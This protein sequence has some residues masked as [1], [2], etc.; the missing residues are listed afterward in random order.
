M[1][2]LESLPFAR[3]ISGSTRLLAV[4]GDPVAHSLS[5]LMHNL[6]LAH[7]GF[8]YR[9]M[10]FHI[11]P[12]QLSEAVRGFAAM[13][14]RGFNAT[15]PHKEALATLMDELSDEARHLKAVNT[16]AI[17]DDGK[18]KGYNTDG[19]GF[20]TDLHQGLGVDPAGRR[21]VVLGAGGACRAVLHALVEAGAAAITLANRTVARAETLA[22]RFSTPSVPIEAVPLMGEKMPL[23]G[24][25]L[26]V[27]VSSIGLHGERFED[28]DLAR[29]PASSAVYDVVYG[30]TPLL[31]DARAQGLAAAD[32]L[33]ML[34][35]QGARAFEIWTGHN[36]PVD[37][38]LEHLRARERSA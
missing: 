30:N 6:A 10:A 25:D 21:V 7:L 18:L 27:N 33:G 1:P 24:C 19:Y 31:Q 26:L 2:D 4:I 8:D 37:M 38:V 9:Y 5:P 14:M 11:R 20:I 12:Q 34:I 3:S 29:L 16:V 32:G 15:I 36:M 28:L 13:G 23:E 35:H 22:A 17:S